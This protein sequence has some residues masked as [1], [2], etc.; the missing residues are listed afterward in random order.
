VIVADASPFAEHTIFMSF[1]AVSA[2]VSVTMAVM[3][4]RVMRMP[5][6]QRCVPVPM[7]MR[8]AR[9]QLGP[10]LMLVMLVVAVPVFVL[11]GVMDVFVVMPLG[12]VE[13]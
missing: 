9:C 3:Q 13:P 2:C 12:Q 8:L 7:R 11:H 5:M 1:S 4:I 6:R 10:V